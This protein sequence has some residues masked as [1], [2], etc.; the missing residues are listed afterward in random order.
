MAEPIQVLTPSLLR[1]Q[2]AEAAGAGIPLA[3]ANHH[4]PGTPLWHQF[5]AAYAAAQIHE[6]EAA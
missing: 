5:N 2:A 4:E 3:E 1:A 6:S